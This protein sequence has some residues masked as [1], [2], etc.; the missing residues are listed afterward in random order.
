M[1]L[2]HGGAFIIGSGN[3]TIQGPDY[4]L[5]QNVIMVAINYRLSVYGNIFYILLGSNL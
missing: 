1:F 4:I 5:E 3:F 2:I